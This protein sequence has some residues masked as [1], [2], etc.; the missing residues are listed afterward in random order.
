MILNNESEAMLTLGTVSRILGLSGH[1][2]A[3]AICPWR[4]CVP[5]SGAGD[6]QALGL[7]KL[8]EQGGGMVIMKFGMINSA[9]VHV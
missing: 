3:D 1:S 2:W 5:A 6:F 7:L 4:P 9:A 8:S